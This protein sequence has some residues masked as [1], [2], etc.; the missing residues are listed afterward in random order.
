MTMK[1]RCL[2]IYLL[3]PLFSSRAQDVPPEIRR[4]ERSVAKILS[5]RHDGSKF[6]VDSC[7]GVFLSKGLVATN[8]HCMESHLDGNSQVSV[9]PRVPE[10]TPAPMLQVEDVVAFSE[11]FD[12]AWS[13]FSRAP[14]QGSPHLWTPSPN[15]KKHST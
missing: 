15:M 9:V 7:S 1:K 6:D 12:L 5:H 8:Y 4:A 11:A 2:I 10:G 14:T 3:L 13:P